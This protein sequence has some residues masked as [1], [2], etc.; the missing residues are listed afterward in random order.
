MT[1][2][3]LNEALAS[4]SVGQLGG[5]LLLCATVA[6]ALGLFFTTRRR[7]CP[8]DVPALPGL[9]FLGSGLSYFAS[10]AK[11]LLEAKKRYNNAPFFLRCFGHEWII[12]S[13]RRDCRSLLSLPER[14]GSMVQANADLAGFALPA[15][16]FEFG[17]EENG[18]NHVSNT[19][20]IAHSVRPAVLKAWEPTLKVR[21][22][23][24]LDNL[25]NTGTLDL[26][27]FCRDVISDV[28]VTV[29][30]GKKA[31]EDEKLKLDLVGLF[32]EADPESG[33]HSPLV[34][35]RAY[36]E[37]K[38]LGERRIYAKIRELL[39]PI[40]D[41]AIEDAISG[42][43][44]SSEEVTVVSSFARLFYERKCDS[45]PDKL[46]SK[47]GDIADNVFTFFFAA[48]SNS[49][50]MAAWT[51]YHIVENTNG[52]GDRVHA[53]IDNSDGN[54]VV[55]L[56]R[57]ILEISRLYTPST[58]LRKLLRP[59]TIPST[60]TTL[61]IGTTVGMSFYSY[62]RDPDIFPNPLDFEPRR[63]DKRSNG[64]GCESE[65]VGFG[66]GG[67]PCPGKKFAMLEIALFVVGIL[68]QLELKAVGKDNNGMEEE[69]KRDAF[70]VASF[71][72]PKHHPEVDISQAGFI[73]R[74]VKP[75]LVEYTQR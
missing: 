26:F 34:A 31:C 45:N 38:V 50:A 72:V 55:E 59:W 9:P 16:T 14:T 29:L 46:R 7:R 70:S 75:V 64:G 3:A 47:R 74:P 8:V 40:V 19:P 56:E 41:D 61:P 13:D 4:S 25:P 53:A 57:C 65:M 44:R 51:L 43:P 67:H 10:P 1:L 35:I 6:A 63:Y 58:V 66:S 60:Q 24:K 12:V 27:S 69:D 28:T 17:K 20:I 22:A 71:S 37:S 2:H 23:A 62:S 68:K 54:R 30:L 18:S 49:F 42:T 39:Y 32:L 11:F 21:I 52:I 15:G 36:L 48:F 33:F 5:S 73:W